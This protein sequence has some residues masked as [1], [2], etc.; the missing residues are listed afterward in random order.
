LSQS[1]E[2]ATSAYK[3]ALTG[4]PAEEYLL[5]RKLSEESIHKFA[6][7]YVDEPAP[8][9]E[10]FQGHLA[11]PYLRRGPL[12]SWKV[13]GIRFRALEPGVRP[14]YN[15]PEGQSLRT[16]NPQAVLT[17]D[18][19]V[20]ICEGEIDAITACQVGLPTVGI[21]GAN[22]WKSWW[23]ELFEPISRVIILAD[24]DE[25]GFEFAAK[26]KA[27]LPQAVILPHQEKQDTNSVLCSEGSEALGALIDK[28]R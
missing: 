7:G 8:G 17:A 1:L 21:P 22:A 2:T 10:R 9:H 14:K 18:E 27:D 15:Q 5:S 11:I 20:G 16:F 3:K 12:G 28:Y 13:A 25:P 19:A 24:G 26:V 23:A 4:S 6:L